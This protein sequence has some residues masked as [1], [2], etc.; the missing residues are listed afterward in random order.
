MANLH[1]SD[2]AEVVSQRYFTS[3]ATGGA[4]NT[5]SAAGGADNTE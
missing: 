4:D 1:N 3:S 2:K 5:G